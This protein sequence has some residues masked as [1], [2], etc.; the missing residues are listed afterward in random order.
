LNDRIHYT[1]CPACG[2]DRLLAAGEVQDFSVSRQLFPL[3]ACKECTLRFTQHAPVAEA[4]APFYQFEQYISHTNTS[5]GLISKVYQWVRKFTLRQ[6]RKLVEKN[7]GIKAG[8]LLDLGCG[9]GA[10]AA[11]MQRAGWQVTALEPDAGA[12][13][14]AL[15]QFGVQA[16]DSA[17]FYTLPAAQFDVITL[18]HVLEHM[19]D[20]KKVLKQLHTLLKPQ[21][22]LFIAVPNFTSYDATVFGEHWAA[23]DVP[24]H[25]YHFSPQ[26]MRSLLSSH[27]L[28]LTDTFPM[29][30]DSFY[31]SLLSTA[32]RSG[33][34]QAG[35]AMLTGLLSNVKALAD[36]EKCSSLIYCCRQWP[37]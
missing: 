10:F 25:L 19:H 17:E 33:R 3:L 32:Y 26:A 12:R 37:H 15:E 21:G 8:H 36:K 24:R 18:W 27:Q 31:V 34:T 2:S 35:K 16:A 30:F 28:V 9:T 7:S 13:K 14:V 11:T 20:L 23:Y 4:A 22:M 29:W 1:T 5:K 6:K